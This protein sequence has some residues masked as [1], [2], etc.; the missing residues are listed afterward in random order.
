MPELILYKNKWL[1]SYETLLFN[2]P[3]GDLDTTQYALDGTG[4]GYYIRTKPKTEA[5]FDWVPLVSDEGV[6]FDISGLKR[7]NIRAGHA[8]Y[9]EFL[10]AV[11]ATNLWTKDS[12]YA[13]KDPSQLPSG[14]VLRV[15][16][17]SKKY[18]DTAQIKDYPQPSRT[19]ITTLIPPEEPILPSQPA[20]SIALD[21]TSNSGIQ[22]NV[23]SYSWSHTCTGTNLLLAFG[24]DHRGSNDRTVTGVTYNSVALAYIRS[25]LQG[26]YYRSTI[27]YLIAPDTGAH[28]VAVT[29]SE[30]V[31]RVLGGVVSYTGAKQSGQP[32]AHNGASGSDATPTVSVTT[33]TDNCWVFDAVM[34]YGTLTC[35]NTERWNIF[36]AGY[37]Y[38]GADTNGPKTPAGAQ[39]MSWTLAGANSWVISAASFAPLVAEAIPRSGFVNFQDP[40]IV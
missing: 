17:T 6:P 18:W 3:D 21:A 1:C 13:D 33:I 40:G 22:L 35:G 27:Y 34:V 32:D 28:T 15:P 26:A 12:I 5:Q 16:S 2:T 9:D 25:D 10:T 37:S 14:S 20:H 30:S 39:T 38:G 19:E 23:S 11:G 36:G 4:T 8:N 29:L 7:V 24:D 31:S